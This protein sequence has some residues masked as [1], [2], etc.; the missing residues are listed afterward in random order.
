MKLF[1][2]L[3][4]GYRTPE[5]TKTHIGEIH[6]GHKEVQEYFGNAMHVFLLDIPR[7]E[8]AAL[9]PKDDYVTLCMLGQ[10]I[11]TELV[12]SFLQ[13]PQV[14]ACFPPGRQIDQV[15]QCAPR[16]N[17]KAA[18]HPFTDRL[19]MIGDSGCT[20]L[21]KDGI[22]AAFRTAKACAATA[23][24]HG[25][26]ADDFKR[27][28]KPAYRAIGIDNAI[29]KLVFFVI[30]RI[31]KISF[32][33]RGIFRMVRKE[34]TVKTIGA[35][36]RMSMVLWDMF[37]GSAPYSN[38][39]LR[40]LHPF[41]LGGLSWNTAAA[42]VKAKNEKPD[43]NQKEPPMTKG[44]LGKIY[45]DNQV[46]VRQG[47]TGDCMYVVQDG[48]VE[49]FRET[50]DSITP[51][52]TL[53]KDDFFGE[54]A[55]FEEEVRSATVRAKGNARVLTVDKKTLMARIQEDPSLAFRMIRKMSH[56]VRELDTELGRINAD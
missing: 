23:V 54:M 28:F 10:K 17:M 48:E 6:L 13:I 3:D 21:Y 5:T 45:K 29:G 47:E 9:I 12:D 35:R 4:F 32:A 56:R 14:R 2:Q 15:C 41:F 46:I 27:R 50:G 33:R 31:Q 36:K 55:L 53:E 43:E 30:R 49:V 51:L 18:V 42:L 52:A 1:E 11:D 44:D 26:S 7:L 8:F 39:F 22:G 24:F 40:T 38:I 25:I 19:V 34:Q 20:R 16:I 37:T